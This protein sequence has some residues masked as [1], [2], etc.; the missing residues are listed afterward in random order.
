MVP[1]LGSHDS[2]RYLSRIQNDG[3]Q[4]NQWEEQ[5]RP[6]TP[7]SASY[8]SAKQGIAWLLTTPGA[9]MLYMGDEFGQHGGADPDN[10]RML[11]FNLNYGQQDLMN[12]TSEIANVRLD[13]EA[14]RRGV[15]STYR[16]ESDMVAYEMTTAEQ[17]LLV[18]LNRGGVNQ[19]QTNYDE[20]ILVIRPYREPLYQSHQIL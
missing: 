6:T 4:W 7:S 3:T 11:D 16:V 20:V 19:L 10:R 2:S 8:Q 5:A 12:F 1:Y 9:P 15:Y 17:S 14:L 13:N 18:V